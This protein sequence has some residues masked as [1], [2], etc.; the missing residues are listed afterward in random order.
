MRLFAKDRI[1]GWL[2]SP[3]LAFHLAVAAFLL[4]LPALGIGFLLDDHYHRTVLLGKGPVGLTPW[5]I[6][7]GPTVDPEL[8]QD[9]ID[10]GV[11][12]WWVSDAFQFSFFRPLSVLSARIDY[13]LW[14]DSA[15]LMHLHSLLWFAAL[16][17]A[18]AVLYRRLMMPAWVAGLAALL[19][20]IDDAHAAPAAWIANRNV[21][22]ACLFG[23]LCLIAHDRWRREGGWVPAVMAP[24]WLA[25]ALASGEAASATAGYLFAYAVY[26]ESGPWRRRWATL[27]PSGAVLLAWASLYRIGDYGAR[28][29]GSYVDP[30]VAPLDFVRALATRAPF[31]LLG[32]WS[33]VPADVGT[34]L[35]PERLGAA[36]AI[37]VGLLAL[38]ALLFWPLVRRERE[39]R[40]WLLGM[41]LSLVPI[42][43]VFPSNRLLF[44][45]GLGAM[46][47][48]GRWL[49]GIWR[50]ADW[51]PDSRGW[52]RVARITAVV[53]AIVHLPL[54]LV[55]M[56][57]GP[58]GVR[59]SGLP[60]DEAA[61]ALPADAAIARQELV[62]VTAPDHLTFVS[63][64][65]TMQLLAK[66][67]SPRRVRALSTGPTAVEIE[68][69][70][71]SSLRVEIER[72]LYAGP[73]GRLF[74]DFKDELAPGDRT[75]LAGMSATVTALDA[76]GDPSEIV[77]E[78]ETPLDDPGRRWI[79]WRDGT[80]AELTLPAIGERLPLAPALG[81]FDLL[82]PASPGPASPPAP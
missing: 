24:V 61:A 26:R 56:P 64:I 82:Y 47:L 25:A 34:L 81:P 79:H 15:A 65:P 71:G 67:P 42:S 40:F 23:V 75:E 37:A 12:P 74:R 45:V 27:A 20:A 3:R 53:L 73:L 43:A 4:T 13:W 54:S 5:Q 33:P 72:G 39:T 9:L 50:A 80:W 68:R 7:S 30:L 11:L 36:W 78:F 51:L 21:L 22:F 8:R 52:R 76:R 31:T 63:H 2:A 38:L 14:P 49:A 28:G 48:L 55:G 35:P 58:L 77:Y 70:D 60:M 66:R 32:Q 16:V 10:Q 69:L 62:L 57:L 41:T 6:F 44:F 46:A 17:G 18:V 1:V 19:Y 59:S 29:S